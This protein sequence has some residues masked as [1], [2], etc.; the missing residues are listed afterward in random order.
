MEPTRTK[1]WRRILVRP[2]ILVQDRDGRIRRM[3]LRGRRRA[4][5]RLSALIFG[6]VVVEHLPA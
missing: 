2:G 6:I 3:A 5:A 4:L 1:W